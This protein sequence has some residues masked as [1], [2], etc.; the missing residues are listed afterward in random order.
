MTNEEK[1]D[2]ANDLTAYI[3][4]PLNNPMTRSQWMQVA[5]IALAALTAQPVKLPIGFTPTISQVGPST[6]STMRFDH[7]GGWLNRTAVILSIRE[8]GYEVQE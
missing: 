3:G 4:Q 5:K 7:K 8:A 6:V 2:I 1:Q